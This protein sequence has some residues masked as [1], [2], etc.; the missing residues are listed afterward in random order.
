MEFLAVIGLT[1]LVMSLMM[2]LQLY[3]DFKY[4]SKVYKELSTMIFYQID[5]TIYIEGWTF[6]RLG[7]GSYMV[8]KNHHLHNSTFFFI[9][10]PYTYYWHR[11]YEKFFKKV[12]PF[13]YKLLIQKQVG[14]MLDG[15]R[16]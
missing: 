2:T 8:A 15:K 1:Y 3:P 6:A 11:K 12:R 4:Y 9:L 13:D 7:S 10:C 14:E 5:D 16:K